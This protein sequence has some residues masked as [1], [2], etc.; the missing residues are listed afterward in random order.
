MRHLSDGTATFDSSDSRQQ[1][2]SQ[3]CNDSTC[4]LALA[5]AMPKDDR[6]ADNFMCTDTASIEVNDNMFVEPEWADSKHSLCRG[7]QLDSCTHRTRVQMLT[8]TTANW[9]MQAQL[10]LG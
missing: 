1:C 10:K 8:G 6:I 3:S 2:S 7:H 4:V 5:T 9:K